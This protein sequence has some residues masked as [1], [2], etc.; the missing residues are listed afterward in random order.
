MTDKQKLFRLTKRLNSEAGGQASAPQAAPRSAKG[1][2]PAHN[3]A[4]NSLEARLRAQMLDGNAA[5]LSLA[6]EADE[7]PLMQVVPSGC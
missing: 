3:P 1:G 7:G 6:D 4:V 5:L 2:K